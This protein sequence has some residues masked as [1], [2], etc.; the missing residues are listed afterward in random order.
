MGRVFDE[1]EIGQRFVTPGRSN[2]PFRYGMCRESG[3][4]WRPY[5]LL[6]DNTKVPV[7]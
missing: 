3:G 6:G 4:E 5:E 2:T 7:Y 1:F